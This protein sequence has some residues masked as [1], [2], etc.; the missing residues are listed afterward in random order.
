M[1][2]LGWAPALRRAQAKHQEALASNEETQA[3]RKSLDPASDT[4]GLSWRIIIVELV[5]R[6]AKDSKGE[7]GNRGRYVLEC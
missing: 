4:G 2:S 1:A 6:E 5:S 3:S 7:T